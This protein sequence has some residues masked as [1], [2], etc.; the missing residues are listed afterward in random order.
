MRDRKYDDGF[1]RAAFEQPDKPL[2]Q[3]MK[4]GEHEI[5]WYESV[6]NVV[7]IQMSE[8]DQ[9]ELIEGAGYEWDHEKG[10]IE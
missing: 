9:I 4:K 6:I 8:A 2:I 10:V 7:A 3:F 5:S 1:I